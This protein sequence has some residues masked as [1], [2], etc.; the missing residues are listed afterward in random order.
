MTISNP[1][2]PNRQPSAG[3]LRAIGALGTLLALAILAASIL[4]RLT[5]HFG[6]D[7]V[8]L[9][10][11]SSENESAIR[12]VHR[13]AATSLGLLTL[14]AAILCWIRRSSLPEAVQPVVWMVASTLLLAVIGPLTPGYRYS[15]VTVANV[16]AGTALLAACWWLR[17]VLA[18]SSASGIG[19]QPQIRFTAAIFFL[20][21]GLGAAASD[22]AMRGIHWVSFVHS[23]SAMLVTLLI[24]SILW[25]S[26]RRPQ[27]AN[28]VAAMAVLL[29]IQI[30]LGLISLWMEGLP[31]GLR[32][33]HAMLSP[34]LV[35]GLVS[36]AVG[37]SLVIPAD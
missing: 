8:P 23:G 34:I 12:M 20:H 30:A 2:Q 29:A 19:Q 15:A 31:L 37:H 1:L 3:G 28:L 24:G 36:I 13:L 25:D 26:R 14:A 32:V 16:V 33:V 21:I 5:T 7:G 18:D 11:L 6:V 27:V 17:E 4:L 22:F 10:S 35:A 9:S